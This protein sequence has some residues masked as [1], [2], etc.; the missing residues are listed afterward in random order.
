MVDVSF[1]IEARA[2]PSLK[3]AVLLLKPVLKIV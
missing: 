1:V 3:M 2:V